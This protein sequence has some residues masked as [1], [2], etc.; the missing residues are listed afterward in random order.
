[1]QSKTSFSMILVVLTVLYSIALVVSNIIAGKLWDPA[2]GLIF[3]AGELLFPIVY[4]IG[5]VV[6]EVY[7]LKVARKIIWI[8]FIANLFAVFFFFVC[9]A[10]PA[11]SFWTNQDAFN[12]VLGF[13]PRLLLASFCGFLVGSNV[14]AWTLVAIK[15]LTGTKWLWVRTIGSTVVGEAVDSILFTTIAFLG[16]VPNDVLGLM[17]FSQWAFKTSYETLATPLTYWVI[18]RVKRIEHIEKYAPPSQFHT[19]LSEGV[20]FPEDLS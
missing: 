17:I 15:K 9:L 19:V 4:I 16:V 10:L 5:D 2:I 18:D 14:N 13:T 6:P 20:A 7:G 1:M 8:G 11:P 12:I 3:T